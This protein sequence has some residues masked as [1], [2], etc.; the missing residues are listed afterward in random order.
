[1]RREPGRPVPRLTLRLAREAQRAKNMAA[2][3]ERVRAFLE[4]KPHVPMRLMAAAL[5][6]WGPS[7]PSLREVADELGVTRDSCWQY[8]CH[9]RKMMRAGGW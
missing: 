3:G 6:Y 7:R 9:F 8:V 2:E 4:S 5:R 1:M